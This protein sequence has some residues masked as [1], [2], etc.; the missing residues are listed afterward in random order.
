LTRLGSAHREQT[1]SAEKRRLKTPVARFSGSIGRR[2][3]MLFARQILKS[4]NKG[5][6]VQK[7]LG[8]GMAEKAADL[9][10][11]QTCAQW[12]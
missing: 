4:E 8:Y 6:L 5:G 12:P 7:P 11:G 1:R 3:D 10:P 2:H 9:S